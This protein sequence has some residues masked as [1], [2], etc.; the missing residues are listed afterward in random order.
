MSIV[1]TYCDVLII[2]FDPFFDL[3]NDVDETNIV[4]VI[5]KWY[6]R[7]E[8]GVPHL[9]QIIRILLDYILHI[10]YRFVQ[11][12]VTYYSLWIQ[13]QQWLFKEFSMLH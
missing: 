9:P 3:F 12:I 13:E 8:Q 5:D 6:V 7:S 11:H 10:V 4:L 1:V 2:F